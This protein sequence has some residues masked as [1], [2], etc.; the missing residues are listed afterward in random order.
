MLLI[1][2]GKS[3]TLAMVAIVLAMSGYEVDCACYSEYLSFRD[4]E[5]FL[6]LF[7]QLGLSEYIKYGTFNNVCETFLTA[8][9]NIRETVSSMILTNADLSVSKVSKPLRNRIL[10]IDEVDVFFSK[11]FYGNIYKPYSRLNNLEIT[12]LIKYIWSI[13]NDLPALRIAS[14]TQ[15]QQYKDC[16]T[17]FPGWEFF[18]E[19]SVKILQR[20]CTNDPSPFKNCRQQ[21]IAQQTRE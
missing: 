20:V 16:F 2:E 10:L 17:K 9:G 12:T 4:Y 19:E 5:S 15:T 13:K 18:I 14:L 1:G 11:E 6:P 3:V 8:R 21:F 7:K